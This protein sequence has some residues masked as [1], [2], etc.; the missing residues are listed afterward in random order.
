MIG[1]NE[2]K[3]TETTIRY[4][5]PLVNGLLFIIVIFKVESGFEILSTNR[6]RWQSFNDTCQ[7]YDELI[8]HYLTAIYL[9]GQQFQAI[10][11]NFLEI[12]D[13]KPI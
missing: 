1:R 7:Q 11:F 6:W 12:I 9:M 10:S 8:S 3:N 2:K 13:L 4:Y 5:P